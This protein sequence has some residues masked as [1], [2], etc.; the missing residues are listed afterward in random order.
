VDLN[1][2]TGDTRDQDLALDDAKHD[3]DKYEHRQ[4]H[5]NG[6]AEAK[7][8]THRPSDPAADH[9]NELGDEDNRDEDSE[10]GQADEIGADPNQRGDDEDNQ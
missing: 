6:V 4:A 5:L 10:I 3:H 9:R 2:A 7:Q 1:R 8:H